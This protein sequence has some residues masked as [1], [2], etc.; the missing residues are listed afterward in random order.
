LPTDPLPVGSQPG[1]KVIRLHDSRPDPAHCSA[2]EFRSSFVSILSP[3]SVLGILLRIRRKYPRVLAGY[4]GF[5]F[6]GKDHE[7]S[8]SLT[9]CPRLLSSFR[10]AKSREILRFLYWAIPNSLFESDTS[11][12]AYPGCSWLLFTLGTTSILVNPPSILGSYLFSIT[13]S[14]AFSCACQITPQ[15]FSRSHRAFPVLD[16]ICYVTTLS[17]ERNLR[18]AMTAFFA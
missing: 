14:R 6:P 9:E 1:I 12:F 18:G 3:P 10:F 16:H 7:R 17:P 13:I 8:H 15:V 11:A 4:P 5:S 2:S